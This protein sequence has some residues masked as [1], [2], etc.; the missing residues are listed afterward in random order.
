MTNF[1]KVLFPQNV[2]CIEWQAADYSEVYVRPGNRAYS[3]G[4][5]AKWVVEGGAPHTATWRISEHDNIQD[6]CD[7]AIKE[8]IDIRDTK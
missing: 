8:L 6:A 7:A 2:E 1:A 5:K 4:P 3:D